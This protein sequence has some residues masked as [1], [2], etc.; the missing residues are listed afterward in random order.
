M[1]HQHHDIRNLPSCVIQVAQ[2]A[3]ESYHVRRSGRRGPMIR[4]AFF[5]HLYPGCPLSVRLKL[6]Y[7][8]SE[9]PPYYCKALQHIMAYFI[10]FCNFSELSSVSL[11]TL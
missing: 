5:L 2:K 7:V 3:A 1:S 8:L 4:P 11:N 6:N 9:M 10:R